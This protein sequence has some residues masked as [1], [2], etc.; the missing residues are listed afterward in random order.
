MYRDPNALYPS[1][2]SL[3]DSIMLL[4]EHLNSFD[5]VFD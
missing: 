1:N 2:M 4:H 3:Y 5:I